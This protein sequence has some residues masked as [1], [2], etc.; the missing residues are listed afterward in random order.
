[1]S[2]GG[3][4]SGGLSREGGRALLM[5]AWAAALRA[6]FKKGPRVR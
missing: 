2:A 6:N 5:F 1:M 4:A 3:R